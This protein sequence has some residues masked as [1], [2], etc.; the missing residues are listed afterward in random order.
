V[1]C[2]SFHVVPCRE[3]RGNF[4]FSVKAFFAAFFKGRSKSSIKQQKKIFSILYR[5]RKF[6]VVEKKGQKTE[7]RRKMK[8]IEKCPQ[9][10][11]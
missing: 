3:E 1:I 10:N 4:K 9:T 5:K 11:F 2:V 8:K 7:K 6:F